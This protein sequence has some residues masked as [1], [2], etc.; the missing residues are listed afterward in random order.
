M[1]KAVGTVSD[2][3]VAVESLDQEDDEDGVSTA[4]TTQAAET[5]AIIKNNKY[6]LFE[7]L[8]SFIDTE[9]ELNPVLCGYFCKTFAQL[10]SNKTK[11]VYSYVYSHP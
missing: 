6:E 10:I 3:E 11:E 2:D 8:L 9:E 7:L 4:P 5:Q 1:S